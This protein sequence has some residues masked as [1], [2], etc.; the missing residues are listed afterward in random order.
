MIFKLGQG[1]VWK[2][3]SEWL[4]ILTGAVASQC[5][6]TQLELQGLLEMLRERIALVAVGETAC[7]VN[8]SYNTCSESLTDSHKLILSVR[9]LQSSQ[10]NVQLKLHLELNWTFPFWKRKLEKKTHTISKEIMHAKCHLLWHTASA[11]SSTLECVIICAHYTHSALCVCVVNIEKWKWTIIL[12]DPLRSLLQ[13]ALVWEK[14]MQRLLEFQAMLDPRKTSTADSCRRSQVRQRWKWNA[15][16]SKGDLSYM[17]MRIIRRSNILGFF[18]LFSISS[19]L[20]KRFLIF[21]VVVASFF[22]FRFFHVL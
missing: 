6:Q 14:Q 20:D 8:K 1:Q 17:R 11:L 9:E 15:E 7:K 19:L 22:F 12:P 3:S 5:I 4:T 13:L 10:L 16:P 18:H 21:L 2:S